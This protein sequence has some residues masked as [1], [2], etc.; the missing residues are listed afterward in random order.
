MATNSKPSAA[1]LR[2]AAAQAEEQESGKRANTALWRVFAFVLWAL[3][4]VAMYCP[5]IGD[6][7]LPF[8]ACRMLFLD[9]VTECI[10]DIVVAGVLCLIA[11]YLWRKANHIHPTESHNKFVQIVWNQLGVVMAGIIFAP[12]AY[13]IIKKSDKL[14]EKTRNTVLG[15]LTAVFLGT[16]AGSADYHPVTQDEVNE[17]LAEAQGEGFNTGD[18]CWT[19]YGKSYHFSNE[20]K[21]LSRSKKENI[22][23]GT[24]EEALN[25][26]RHDACDFCAK[27]DAAKQNALKE[28]KGAV[29]T[30][31][32]K[33]GE[34]VEEAKEGLS[35]ASKEL[36]AEME[37]AAEALQNEIDD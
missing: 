10:I 12:L 16:A 6:M 9:C 29:E 23:N 34:A 19:K 30:A 13:I 4:A 18:V 24:L 20:C 11:A 37:E 5:Q 21:T 35:E 36:K 8:G 31:V 27:A 7:D 2:A 26:N 33:A 3:A 1:A 22:M 25:S 15:V 32:E 28:A 14:D 17:V